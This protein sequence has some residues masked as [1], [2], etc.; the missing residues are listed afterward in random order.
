MSSCVLQKNTLTEVFDN[1]LGAF[2][3]N[4][5]QSSCIQCYTHCESYILHSH[6][7]VCCILSSYSKLN[8]NPSNFFKHSASPACAF[9]FFTV[10][11][12]FFSWWRVTVNNTATHCSENSCTVLSPAYMVPPHWVKKTYGYA[13]FMHKCLYVLES[14]IQEA[15]YE[16]NKKM[17]LL[18]AD[19][20]I[21]K[22]EMWYF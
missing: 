2:T 5:N 3:E 22:K 20:P 17:N 18:H 16:P 21:L 14:H 4:W 13:E 15:L 1:S 11:F 12:S 7:Q 10:H 6:E 9:G 8:V 19:H